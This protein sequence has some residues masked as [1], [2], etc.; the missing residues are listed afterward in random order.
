MN[1]ED[2]DRIAKAFSP[3]PSILMLAVLAG[4]L[5]IGIFV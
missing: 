3:Y 4:V 2:I 5:I 1:Q